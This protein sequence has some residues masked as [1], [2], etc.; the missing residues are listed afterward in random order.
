MNDE[1]TKLLIQTFSKDHSGIVQTNDKASGKENLFPRLTEDEL[2]KIM[3][4]ATSHN[5]EKDNTLVKFKKGPEIEN[6]ITFYAEKIGEQLKIYVML[7]SKIVD[8]DG[9]IIKLDYNEK[10]YINVIQKGTF[11]KY[12]DCI[13]LTID[14][15]ESKEEPESTTKKPVLTDIQLHGCLISLKENS[16]YE[17]SEE[18]KHEIGLQKVL[19][20]ELTIKEVESEI[21]GKYFT[22]V[23]KAKYGSMI[24]YLKKKPKPD[25]NTILKLYGQVIQQVKEMHAMGICHNDIKPENILIF[26]DENGNPY[27]RLTDFGTVQIIGEVKKT[28][29]GTPYYMPTI[30]QLNDVKRQINKAH[31]N[32]E[33]KTIYNALNK[34][35]DNNFVLKEKLF[36]S[37]IQD[38][39]GLTLGIYSSIKKY[40]TDNENK[41]TI[42]QQLK[43]LLTSESYQS[44]DEADN[45]NKLAK[46]LQPYH[47]P[48]TNESNS[49]NTAE[50]SKK[51]KQL[52]SPQVNAERY[53]SQAYD[54]LLEYVVEIGK[55]SSYFLSQN[56][57]Y[58]RKYQT[59]YEIIT[60]LL[61]SKDKKTF[62][63]LLIKTHANLKEIKNIDNSQKNKEISN[64]KY[65]TYE[66]GALIYTF[67]TQNKTK[68]DEDKSN[69]DTLI[70]FKQTLKELEKMELKYTEINDNNL[71][72]SLNNNFFDFIKTK[73]QTDAEKNSPEQTNTIFSDDQINKECFLW[74]KQ[75][76]TKNKNDADDITG[77]IYFIDENKFKELFTTQKYEMSVLMV[78]WLIHYLESELSKEPNNEIIQ[79]LKNSPL[80]LLQAM[81]Y[82][83][84]SFS[85]DNREKYLTIINDIISEPKESSPT[86]PQTR[87]DTLNLKQ[88]TSKTDRLT[89]QI[90]DIIKKINE[91]NDN[92]K[93]DNLNKNLKSIF[94]LVYQNKAEIQNYFLKK[95]EIK[96]NSYMEF[97]KILI[98][99]YEKYKERGHEI[100]ATDEKGGRN[101]LVFPN[102]A[103]HFVLLA[104]ELKG[105]NL[106]Y[107]IDSQQLQ[108][109]AAN[110]FPTL[111]DTKTN[112]ASVIITTRVESGMTDYE[113]LSIR[114]KTIHTGFD[115]GSREMPTIENLK[116]ASKDIAKTAFNIKE[117]MCISVTRITKTPNNPTGGNAAPNESPAEKDSPE[118]LKDLVSYPN[119]AMNGG[120]GI[121]LSRYP[122]NYTCD[123]SI[124][125]S[126]KEAKF[127]NSLIEKLNNNT[128]LKN[129]LQSIFKKLPSILSAGSTTTDLSTLYN[130]NQNNNAYLLTSLYKILA[131]I[132][133]DAFLTSYDE[134]NN[135]YSTIKESA[136]D[137]R[138][139]ANIT[140]DDHYNM[141]LPDNTS[142]LANVAKLIDTG[143]RATFSMTDEDHKEI[144]DQIL[145][146]I[147]KNNENKEAQY[148]FVKGYPLLTLQSN[149]K[150]DK[151]P[152][153]TIIYKA[154]R[155]YEESKAVAINTVTETVSGIQFGNLPTNKLI[156]NPDAYT[157]ATRQFVALHQEE[158][159][160]LQDPKEGNQDTFE[161]AMSGNVDITTFLMQVHAF[162]DSLD[163]SDINKLSFNTKNLTIKPLALGANDQ[164]IKNFL[165]LC[166]TMKIDFPKDIANKLLQNTNTT[167]QAI[168]LQMLPPEKQ[169]VHAGQ[170]IAITNAAIDLIYKLDSDDDAMTAL[171][172]TLGTLNINGKIEELN[173]KLKDNSLAKIKKNKDNMIKSFAGVDIGY[174]QS[175]VHSPNLRSRLGI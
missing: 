17:H 144:N 129:P 44:F 75:I 74:C 52:L 133:T 147:N 29:L 136:K 105:I 94:E 111:R 2:T 169:K 51:L 138:N 21:D 172:N 149:S 41:E 70:H 53:L 19:N 76:F 131:T 121:E 15:T 28:A 85:K 49:L 170:N 8:S 171:K 72:D 39:W 128:S 139:E 110:H 30:G 156:L 1:K 23:K 34:T 12:S 56:S 130:D 165:M 87:L 141:L 67:S 175:E 79:E 160:A 60:K 142:I 27:A 126:E 13:E 134:L 90:E 38:N 109:L 77:V 161:I 25:L 40:F 9:N 151:E 47:I 91:Y 101:M 16:K 154:E 14:K 93:A 95:Q 113:K 116:K 152:Y 159:S 157:A 125:N 11:K 173:S 36:A 33:D 103:I 32:E 63:E 118:Q 140:D 73:L 7:Q 92:I 127:L 104:L 66:I 137:A 65:M 119:A 83:T 10:N 3:S 50:Q 54:T 22:I 132:D 89:M 162:S 148:E 58:I 98:A 86:T 100:E 122:K 167:L 57:E 117:G 102:A 135:I 153:A 46:I 55:N 31:M 81:E 96:G 124:N 35:N 166:T 24:D 97:Q 82:S 99:I 6:Q 62:Q 143:F 163:A 145:E 155:K 115:S 43:E 45:L 114:L 168:G 4:I 18:I 84:D 174:R 20:P 59:F 123:Q 61:E 42:L 107:P 69:T 108:E 120:G 106:T 5:F 112:K 71:S 80:A 26:E 78:E 37:T 48:Q 150:D 146:K 64:L 158:L 68:H 164:A 88:N